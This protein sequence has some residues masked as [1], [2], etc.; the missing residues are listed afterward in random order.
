[1]AAIVYLD[2]DDEI[3]SAAARIR[4]LTDDRIALVLPLGS[5]LSTS[6]INFRLL[7]REAEARGHQIEIVTNDASA[8]AL[9][10]SAGLATHVSVAAFEGRP[11]P[12]DAPRAGDSP[13]RAGA[14]PRDALPEEDRPDPVAD[15]ATIALPA[16]RRPADRPAVP[17]VGTRSPRR[18]SWLPLVIVVAVAAVLVAGGAAAFTLL[19][20]ADITLTRATTEIGPVELNVTAQT[21]VTQPDPANLLVPARRYTFDLDA[22]ASFP[23]TGVKVTETAATGTVTFSSLNTGS[24]NTI[25]AHSTVRTESGIEFT[26]DAAVTLPP[27]DIAFDPGKGFIVVPSTRKVGVTAVTSGISGNVDA[28]TIIVVPPGEDPTRTTV[29]NETPTTGGTHTESPIVQQSDIDAALASLDTTIAGQ[30]DDKIAAADGIPA[31]TTLFP[32]TRQ[33]G[34]ATPTVDPSTLLDQEVATFDLE[35]TAQGSVLGVDP[36]PVGTLAD[37]RLR[38]LVDTGFE[39]DEASIDIEVGTPIVAGS[40]VTFP[41]SVSARA[42]RRV[43]GPALLARVRGLGLPQARTVLGA[44]GQV[45]ITVW[46][47]WVT[48]IPTGDGQATLTVVAGPDASAGPT[49]PGTPVV[50]SPSP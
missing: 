3:T 43:D 34:A 6:R 30:L 12:G 31:G 13:S 26:T 37:A 21:G 4:G 1:M 8:R 40:V 48:T 20:H 10:A 33:L 22:S 11:A 14:V 19:P 45:Q 49:T 35:V 29:T 18:R 42:V 17:R 28:N 44:Y 24:S 25:R 9:A 38:N 2:V 7:A 5:R 46:P 16:I 39:L 15:S 27:A 47:D 32:E 36:S 23:A 50:G 41:V